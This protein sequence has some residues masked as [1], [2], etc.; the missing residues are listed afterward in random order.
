MSRTYRCKVK[1]SVSVAVR[2]GEGVDYKLRLNDILDK[3]ETDD[4]LRSKL[5]DAGG[6][7]Q[8]D[9]K[10]VVLDVDGV[11]VE[12]DVEE[13][14]ATARTKDAP[15]EV[16]REFDGEI[17][18]YS[19]HDRR[20]EAQEKAEREIEKQLHD[21]VERERRRLVEGARKT[22]GEASDKVTGVLR[23]ATAETEKESAIRKADKIGKVL[24]V[25]ESDEPNGD[26]RIEI[27]IEI[28][29]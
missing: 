21:E 18:S 27:E 7:T 8:D 17:G 5:V 9:G 24:S 12:V 25:K 11:E 1:K 20:S 29:E 13:R 6:T 22:L 14:T 26:R 19:W 2:V 4:I 23:K 28:P 10:T 16:R 3:G 15:H